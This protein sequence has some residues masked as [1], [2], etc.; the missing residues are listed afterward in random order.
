M[1]FNSIPLN[2]AQFKEGIF[3]GGIIL[4][5]NTSS[6]ANLDDVSNELIVLDCKNDPV[7]P[8]T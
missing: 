3:L 8:N 7:F 6:H 2:G 5:I 4:W 1:D